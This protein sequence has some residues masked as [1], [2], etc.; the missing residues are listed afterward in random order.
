[1]KERPNG[2]QFKREI[3]VE[4]SLKILSSYIELF[5]VFLV[6]WLVI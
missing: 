6:L 2:N 1:M 5:M 3:G 4:G